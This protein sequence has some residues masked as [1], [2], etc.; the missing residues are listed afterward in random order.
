M[1]MLL[2]P[3]EELTNEG[4]PLGT[5]GASLDWGRP[6]VAAVPRYFIEKGL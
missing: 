5:L 4:Q 6:E 1:P 2:A 3:N